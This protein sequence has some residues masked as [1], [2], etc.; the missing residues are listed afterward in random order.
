M[1][2]EKQ[3]KPVL[4][5]M[6]VPFPS[7]AFF[8]WNGSGDFISVVS[9]GTDGPAFQSPWSPMAALGM[10]SWFGSGA[11]V[12]NNFKLVRGK[13]FALTSP[14]TPPSWFSGN[15]FKGKDTVDA[16]TDWSTLSAGTYSIWLLKKIKRKNDSSERNSP[17]ENQFGVALSTLDSNP[18][19][20]QWFRLASSS[21]WSPFVD[22]S[23]NPVQFD[24]VTDEYV[25]FE[26]TSV[27]VA[28]NQWQR[29]AKN[30]T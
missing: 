6:P 30:L 20:V 19:S 13:Q 14:G 9:A 16:S 25:S 4:K 8:H 26:M 5:Q 18:A 10:E 28:A 17:I 27:N 15:T 3:K 11:N 7:F 1:P 23:P 21:F 12:P 29:R 2:A 24:P 22:G